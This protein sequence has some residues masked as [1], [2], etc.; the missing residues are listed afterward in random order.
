MTYRTRSYGSRMNPNHDAHRHLCERVRRGSSPIHQCIFIQLDAM[1]K[2]G[3]RTISRR[4]QDR[5]LGWRDRGTAGHTTNHW[6]RQPRPQFMS[7]F[8]CS[9]APRTHS[10]SLDLDLRCDVVKPD[11]SSAAVRHGRALRDRK[12][13]ETVESV[14][15]ARPDLVTCQ[16]PAVAPPAH[17]SLLFVNCASVASLPTK[18]AQ[19]ARVCSKIRADRMLV[20]RD[21]P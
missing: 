15:T 4:L 9:R 11:C 18:L 12:C 17:N 3:S 16:S 13:V 10:F 6:L 20:Y 8:C 19:S 5:V 2:S 1:A 21:F 7:F 14:S